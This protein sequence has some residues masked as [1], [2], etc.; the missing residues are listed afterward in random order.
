[1]IL[2]KKTLPITKCMSILLLLSSH[3]I[4]AGVSKYDY[5]SLRF[6]ASM[7]SEKAQVH[8]F[9][10]KIN[11][12]VYNVTYALKPTA[13][14]R[15]V[16]SIYIPENANNSS[17]VFIPLTTET[18][19][20]SAILKPSDVTRLNVNEP[21]TRT[22][23]AGASRAAALAL[24]KGMIVVSPATRGSDSRDMING[25]LVEDGNGAAAIVDLKA[26]IRYL[27]FNDNRM[28]GDA[29]LIV[30]SGTGEGGEYSSVIGSSGDSA[31]FDR[32]LED[33]GSAPGSDSVYAVAPYCPETDLD[34]A[35]IS[36]E[37]F[38]GLQAWDFQEVMFRWLQRIR[39]IT[40]IRPK[41]CNSLINWLPCIRF[42]LTIWSF[43]GLIIYSC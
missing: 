10:N 28:K 18:Y 3:N 17:P 21:G 19:L 30:I 5:S 40:N 29:N 23:G 41:I 6:D 27:K 26:A 42:I 25:Q 11:Y 34:N 1:M 37:Y 35:K 33:I 8:V 4:Y 15:Q 7:I 36:F 22:T 2:R 14:G 39:L 43:P 38:L 9:G 24:S 16:M 32:Y 13:P 31:Y 12:S 20:G